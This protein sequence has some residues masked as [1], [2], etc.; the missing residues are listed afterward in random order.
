MNNHFRP[1]RFITMFSS[2]V[3]QSDRFSKFSQW[4]T[5]CGLWVTVA[6]DWWWGQQQLYSTSSTGT[7]N[8][9]SLI[10]DT[11]NVTSVL[12][13]YFEKCRQ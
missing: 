6:G 11:F 5:Y 12:C 1:F 2:Y 9:L 4:H 13:D 3:R 10:L 8:E 7:V